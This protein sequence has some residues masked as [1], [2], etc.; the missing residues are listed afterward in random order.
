[1]LDT[2]PREPDPAVGGPL[3]LPETDHVAST[4]EA[5]DGIFR[6]QERLRGLVGIGFVALAAGFASLIIGNLSPGTFTHVLSYRPVVQHALNQVDRLLADAGE[7]LVPL[8][9]LVVGGVKLWGSR[10]AAVAQMDAWSS[11]ELTDLGR[12]S[13]TLRR[14]L[15]QAVAA[16]GVPIVAATGVGLAALTTSIG[17]EVSNGPNR[18]IAAVLARLAPGKEMVVGYGAAMPMVESDI[19]LALA[20]RVLRNARQ[21]N[22]PAHVLG[23]DLGTIVVKGQLLTSLSI[24]VQVT[25]GSN[26]RWPASAGC[27]SI[28]VMIDQIAGVPVGASITND[29]YTARVVAET[30]GI[31]ATNRIGLVMDEAA[32]ATCFKKDPT[33]PVQAVVLAASPITADSILAAA[34]LNRETA[35]VIS[36]RHYIANSQAF[37]TSNVKPITNLLALV[38]GMLALIAMAGTVSGRLLRNRREY[39]AKLAGGATSRALRATELLRATKDALV[40]AVL[41][42]LL[43][44]VLVPL[45][46][47]L[48]P[49]FQAGL[50]LDDIM[51]GCAIGIIGCGAGAAIRTARLERAVNVPESTRI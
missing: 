12:R 49:G 8:A 2:G 44:A 10:S 27:R 11:R 51:V 7:V 17:N 13:T 41:G 5:I 21:R 3:V 26:L 16:G 28:P 9:L 31:S 50:S 40:A 6:R 19:S 30:S 24:G 29:G 18:P 46:N 48:E 32:M 36:A 20:D 43:A 15:L 47:A 42:T 22:V 4:A 14:R 1:M 37:W 45:T 23:L 35:V 25:S 34:N 33:A 39:A 38:A